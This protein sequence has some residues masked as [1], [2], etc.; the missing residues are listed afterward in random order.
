MNLIGKNGYTFN[1]L[2]KINVVLGKNGCGKS[3]ALKKV[4]Q[5]LETD[6]EM[7]K[8]KYITLSVVVH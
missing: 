7:G 2:S 6:P 3:T 8:T 5:A 4:Q 1:N